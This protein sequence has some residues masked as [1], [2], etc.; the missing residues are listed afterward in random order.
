MEWGCGLE[1]PGAFT[2]HV[3]ASGWYAPDEEVD[4][5]LVDDACGH[6][7]TEEVAIELQPQFQA[8]EPP[9]G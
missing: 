2:L 8:V 1:E 7:A 3:E 6:V 4:V 9:R 5:D